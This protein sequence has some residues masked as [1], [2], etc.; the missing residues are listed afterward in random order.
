MFRSLFPSFQQPADR[1]RYLNIEPEGRNFRGVGIVLLLAAVCGV[2]VALWEPSNQITSPFVTAATPR[3][4]PATV[5]A[6]PETAAVDTDDDDDDQVTPTVKLTTLCSQRA[7]ARRDCAN[8]KAM[9]DARLNAPDPEAAVAPA[10]EVKPATVAVEVSSPEPK[11]AAVTAKPSG[12]EPKPAA[13]PASKPALVAA[14]T[15][16]PVPPAVAPAPAA[17]QSVAV[18]TPEESHPV[19]PA[20]IPGAQQ[21]KT[22]SASK[23]K[24]QR[25]AEEPVERLVRVYDQVLPDGRRVPVYRRVG[26][27][28]LETGVIVDGEYRPARRAYLDQPSGRFGLQ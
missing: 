17:T 18:V 27:G 12:P 5:G 22:T 16:N 1:P 28:G 15:S 6:Q 14:K 8:V 11:P 3:S 4:A 7:T 23:V 21:P 13:A 25:P 24:R 20:D 19:P 26:T 2:A 9:K 10:E